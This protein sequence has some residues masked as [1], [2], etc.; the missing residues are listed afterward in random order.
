MVAA[1]FVAFTALATVASA[2][3]V[4]S[5]LQNVLPLSYGRFPCTVWDKN[6]KMRGGAFD[7]SSSFAPLHMR[8]QHFA[9]LKSVRYAD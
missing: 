4:L 9:R 7:V 8:L 2:T 6:G 5:G 3:P 1:A